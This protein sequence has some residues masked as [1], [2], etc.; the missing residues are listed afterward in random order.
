MCQWIS[1]WVLPNGDVLCKPEIVSHDLIAKE[2]G[3]NTRDTG[4]AVKIEFTPGAS[5]LE[6]DSWTL[7]LDEP[8]EPEWWKSA[9]EGVRERMKQIARSAIPTDGAHSFD[10]GYHAIAGTARATVSGGDAGFHGQSQGTVS[11]GSARFYGQSQGTVSGGEAM[12]YGQSASLT[13]E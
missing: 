6:F 10:K 11:G 1:A 2:L 13:T 7:T 8:D 9:I 3:I 4:R 5:L 12:F